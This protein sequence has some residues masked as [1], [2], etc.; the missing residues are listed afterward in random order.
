MDQSLSQILR[1]AVGQP[2]ETA[3][4]TEQGQAAIVE[5]LRALAA[6]GGQHT[7]WMK[8]AALAQALGLDDEHEPHFQADMQ[9]LYDAGLIRL[10]SGGKAGGRDF[11]EA[12]LIPP[13][14]VK[15]D[16]E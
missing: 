2:R 16:R 6:R 4:A 3:S 14:Q 8:A 7:P 11:Y 15:A 5:T 10:M 13:E 9:A 1:P 12:M